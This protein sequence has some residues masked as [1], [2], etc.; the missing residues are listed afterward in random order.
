MHAPMMK[1]IETDMPDDIK[2]FSGLEESRVRGIE[3]MA[4]IRAGLM[5]PDS[6]APFYLSY[7]NQVDLLEAWEDLVTR[8]ECKDAPE[9]QSKIASLEQECDRLNQANMELNA[10]L[11]FNESQCSALSS[12][13][14]RLRDAIKAAMKQRDDAAK[15]SVERFNEIAST[16]AEN[17]ELRK[18]LSVLRRALNAANGVIGHFT[19]RK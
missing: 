8:A 19:G 4:A 1:A 15:L 2:Q 10:S 9:L 16:K 12:D 17:K 13:A 11:R 3:T 6:K 7:E 18:E 5:N 14:A